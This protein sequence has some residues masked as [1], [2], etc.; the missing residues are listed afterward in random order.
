MDYDWCPQWAC[1]N[2]FDCLQAIRKQAIVVG[3]RKK[4]VCTQQPFVSL[5]PCPPL[6]ELHVCLFMP[7]GRRSR[8]MVVATKPKSIKFESGF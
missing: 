8:F 6:F 5:S 7:G 1:A 2:A 3:D 4:I